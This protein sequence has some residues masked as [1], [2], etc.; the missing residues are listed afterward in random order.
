MSEEPIV[1][2]AAATSSG[3]KKLSK[4]VEEAMSAAVMKASRE[5]VNKPE[6]IKALMMQ[7]RQRVLDENR[8]QPEV[9]SED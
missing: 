1:A 8:A 3:G 9:P 6:D 2:E 4:L 5:G 7:A